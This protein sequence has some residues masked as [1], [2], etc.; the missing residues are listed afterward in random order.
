M[1]AQILFDHADCA[2][3]VVF[4]RESE[5]ADHIAAFALDTPLMETQ[6]Q[7]R[8]QLTTAVRLIPVAAPSAG[9]IHAF[10]SSVT[11]SAAVLA[12]L[13]AAVQHVRLG[14][15]KDA[16]IAA[17]IGRDNGNAMTTMYQFLED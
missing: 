14:V 2:A 7:R 11:G 17:A 12:C 15:D 1:P 8:H 5:G 4:S 3:V 9:W 16:L 6:Y 13:R 10:L